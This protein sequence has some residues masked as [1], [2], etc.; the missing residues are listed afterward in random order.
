MLYGLLKL[1]PEMIYSFEKDS[2][3]VIL[4]INLYGDV[5]MMVIGNFTKA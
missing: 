3:Q 5:H 2:Y 1:Y 4:M